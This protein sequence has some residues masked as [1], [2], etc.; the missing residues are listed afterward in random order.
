[1]NSALSSCNIVCL[2][3]SF[4]R[5]L[6]YYLKRFV[7]KGTLKAYFNPIEKLGNIPQTEVFTENLSGGVGLF[8]HLIRKD[9]QEF[10]TK[11]FKGKIKFYNDKPEDC[12]E[13]DLPF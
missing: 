12:I 10:Y 7:F 3:H 1:M 13:Y 4:E 5:I 11:T 8:G 9:I 2:L 6:F